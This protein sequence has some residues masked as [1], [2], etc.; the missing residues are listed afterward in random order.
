MNSSSFR[1]LEKLRTTVVRRGNMNNDYAQINDSLTR[2][3][4]SIL[5]LCTWREAGG[6]TILK[7]SWPSGCSCELAIGATVRTAE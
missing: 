7:H 1:H 5:V 3:P 6:S 2:R 4:L